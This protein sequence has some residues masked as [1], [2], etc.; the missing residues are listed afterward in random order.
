MIH[1]L[2]R[3]ESKDHK[4]RLFRINKIC[5]SF[6][7]DKKFILKDEYSRLSHVHKFTP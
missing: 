5:F 3:I 6:Y 2:N 7:N 4:A 1:K